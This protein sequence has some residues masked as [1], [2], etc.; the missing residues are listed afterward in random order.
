MIIL[1]E[2]PIMVGDYGFVTQLLN[3]RDESQFIGSG[4]RIIK[5][6]TTVGSIIQQGQQHQR[7]HLGI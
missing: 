6:L 4:C 7:H 5:I 2:Q 1:S 3:Y